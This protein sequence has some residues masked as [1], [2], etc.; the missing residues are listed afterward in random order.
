M[1]IVKVAIIIFLLSTESALG[2]LDKGGR[3]GEV[4]FGLPT[5]SESREA[6]YD[7]YKLCFMA[8]M[9]PGKYEDKVCKEHPM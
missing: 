3:Y 1:V 7:Y 6:V 9:T 4:K 8:D 5:I 2:N